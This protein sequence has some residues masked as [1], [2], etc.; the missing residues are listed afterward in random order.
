[1]ASKYRAPANP[2]KA[3]A[4][5]E[6]ARSNAWGTHDNRPKRERSRA[7]SKRAAIRRDAA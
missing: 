7:D 6:R 4:D 3:Q 2:V 5:A 1:M